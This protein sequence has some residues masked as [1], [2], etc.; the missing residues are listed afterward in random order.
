MYAYGV[1]EPANGE[2]VQLWMMGLVCQ[3]LNIKWLRYAYFYSYN[4]L[5]DIILCIVC[6]LLLS[7]HLK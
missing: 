4:F 6:C 7:Y 3:N 2:V 1:L 5:Y